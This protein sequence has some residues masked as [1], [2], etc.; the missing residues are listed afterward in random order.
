MN[1]SITA[2]LFHFLNIL[3]G[4]S[5]TNKHSIQDFNVE[6]DINNVLSLDTWNLMI[7]CLS[8]I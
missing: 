2:L 1:L 4:K 8:D 3:S 6:D 5:T 7:V